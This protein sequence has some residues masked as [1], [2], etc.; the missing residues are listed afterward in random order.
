MGICH[1]SK[2]LVG[3]WFRRQIGSRNRDGI[4]E[5]GK[6]KSLGKVLIPVE[7]LETQGQAHLL[8][9]LCPKPTGGPRLAEI[10]VSADSNG[11]DQCPKMQLH[12][13]LLGLILAQLRLEKGVGNIPWG[14]FKRLGLLSEEAVKVCVCEGGGSVWG[15]GPCVLG[16]IN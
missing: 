6:K 13:P 4:Q 2:Q 3:K 8:I 11:L 1:S 12:G 9:I 14:Y 5:A 7:T 16:S 15:Q 10:G